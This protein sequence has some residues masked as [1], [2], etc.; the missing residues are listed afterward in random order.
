MKR[1]RFTP[2]LTGDWMADYQG[3]E[4]LGV[5]SGSGKGMCWVP[6]VSNISWL[7]TDARLQA[8]LLDHAWQSG[9]SVIGY[10]PITRM[11]FEGTWC[12][13]ACAVLRDRMM[14]LSR[15]SDLT[16]LSWMLCATMKLAWCHAF[17]S[18]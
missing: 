2:G 11:G 5:P 16:L 18:P 1:P 7:K 17:N 3:C 14:K 15:N 6:S 9:G 10:L 12:F 13:R 8:Q 4:L